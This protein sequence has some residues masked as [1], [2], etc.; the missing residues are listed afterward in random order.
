MSGD[1]SKWGGPEGIPSN[2][3]EQRGQ[4]DN[5]GQRPAVNSE[6]FDPKYTGDG[7]AVWDAPRT[8]GNVPV[9]NSK[10]S[11]DFVKRPASRNK[12]FNPAQYG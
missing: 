10:L 11:N 8:V 12:P 3:P 1:F 9:D 2:D 5:D 4:A 7:T 6:G